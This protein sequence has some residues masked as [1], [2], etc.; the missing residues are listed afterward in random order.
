MQRFLLRCAGWL[1]ELHE[2][3]QQSRID[4]LICLIIFLPTFLVTS[5]FV[6]NEKVSVLYAGGFAISIYLIGRLYFRRLLER[7]ESDTPS[8]LPLGELS[9][10]QLYIEKQKALRAGDTSRVTS[11]DKEVSL[12]R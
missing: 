8:S 6:D 9:R 5:R 4:Q 10:Y 3:D 12:R 7:P 11:V 1:R 2:Q